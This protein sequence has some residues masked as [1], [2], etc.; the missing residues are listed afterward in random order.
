MQAP[1]PVEIRHGFARDTA[2]VA[3]F[4]LGEA[5]RTRALIVMLFMFVGVGALGAWGFS[6]AVEGVE[7]NAARVTGAP[8]TR[9]PGGV[10]SGLKNSTTYRQALKAFL[11]D[12]EKADYFAARPPIVL[13]FGWATL[14]FTPWLILLTA[15]ETI[16]SEVSSRAIRYTALRTSRLAFA[17]GKALGQGNENVAGA[18]DLVHPGDGIGTEGQGGH[19]LGA[20][21]AEQ[22]IHPRY[23][24]GH[25][26]QGRHGASGGGRRGDKHLPD[27]GHPGRYGR[28]QHR[29]WVDHLPAGDVDA[30][31]SDGPHHLPQPIG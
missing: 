3:R 16:A 18:A 28:H 25:Q 2:L 19:G 27:A 23:V 4:E 11:R 7:S 1:A 13:F 6:R 17:L 15:A 24:G 22:P 10:F 29:R 30:H 14:L 5:L 31:P 9:R 21:G 20:A 12:D 8:T 26:L